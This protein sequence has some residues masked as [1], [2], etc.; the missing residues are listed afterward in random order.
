ANALRH[1]ATR[2]ARHCRDRRR[3]RERTMAQRVP[4]FARR[5]DLRRDRRG[6][7]QHHRPTPVGAR[8]RRMM[9]PAE[10]ALLE[11]TVRDAVARR[12]NDG[13][14][15]DSV[16]A[17]LGWLEMLEAEPRDAIDVVFSTL[18]ATNTTASALDDVVV[19][20]IGLEPRSDLAFL[21]PPF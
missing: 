10:R 12:A 8:E 2:L 16:L 1:R 17:D 19:D 21:L 5:D 18:G 15:I 14:A 20:A 9:D 11:T 3:E 6:A 7:A 13:A 4:V